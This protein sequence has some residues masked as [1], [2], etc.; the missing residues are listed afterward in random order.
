M[1]PNDRRLVMHKPLDFRR[2]RRG[3]GITSA[4]SHPELIS[5]D[6]AVPPRRHVSITSLDR[7]VVQ[8]GRRALGGT[9]AIG[10]IAVL[11]LAVALR[12]GATAGS[13][14]DPQ[15]LARTCLQWHM[16]ASAVVSRQIQSTRDADLAMVTHSV[17]RMRRA[18]RNCELGEVAQA[19]EDYHAVA[20]SLPGFAISNELFACSRIA[21]IATQ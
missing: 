21:V 6:F 16:A 17:D 5:G 4:S 7:S 13:D 18:R 10:A 14:T 12:S 9:L 15:K 19:C 20:A 3:E 8:D 2:P 1:A 11:L